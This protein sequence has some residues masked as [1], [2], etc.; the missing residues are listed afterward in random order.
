[1]RS[2]AKVVVITCVAAV[3]CV[4]TVVSRHQGNAHVRVVAPFFADADRTCSLV[5]LR[6][7]CEWDGATTRV[8]WTWKAHHLPN[9]RR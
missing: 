2:N 7:D 3:A 6:V 9:L 4:S 8:E 5:S 1:M